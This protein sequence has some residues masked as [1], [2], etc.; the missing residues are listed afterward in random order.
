MRSSARALRRHI[1]ATVGITI[2]VVG[3]VAAA[4]FRVTR[5]ESDRHA[6]VTAERVADVADVLAEIDFD[7][8]AAAW[9]A[10]HDVLTPLVTTKVVDR[11]KIWR[12]EGADVRVVYSDEPRLIDT[13]RPFDAELAERLDAGEVVVYAVPDDHEHR[14]EQEGRMREAYMGFS[15]ASGTPM[16]MELYV[17]ADPGESLMRSLRVHVPLL[18]GG[19]IVLGAL[20]TPLSVRAMRRIDRLAKERQDALAY[21]LTASEAVR[22]DLAHRLHDG[23][24]QDLAAVRLTLGSLAEQHP[25]A[26]DMLRRLADL[27]GTDIDDLRRLAHESAPLPDTSLAEHLAR[28]VRREESGVELSVEEPG[29]LPATATATLLWRVAG[30]LVL[31]ALKHARPT[32]IDVRLT[33]GDEGLMLSV[34]DD[35]I[36]LTDDG[37][38]DGLGLLLVD[39]AVTVEGGTFTIRGTP[40]SGTTATVTLPSPPS[41]E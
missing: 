17:T 29:D 34:S 37:G 8:Q 3:L 38:S 28:F 36:G 4:E 25:R 9:E 12:V 39:H 15:D 26:A 31:N 27:V 19:L 2:L 7:D 16:R 5:Q 32:R 23:V 18:A 6:H 30:E 11:V 22:H 14:Y 13:V 1:L 24:I 40:G 21:G 35:G 41:G 10:A 33:R 20:L